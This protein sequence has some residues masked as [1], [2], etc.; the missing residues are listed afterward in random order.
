MMSTTVQKLL[1]LTRLSTDKVEHKFETIDLSEII[2]SARQ[3]TGFIVCEIK[4]TGIGIP[5]GDL[6][7]VFDRF[8]QVDKSRSKE[9]GSSGLG[10]SICHEIVKLHGGAGKLSHPTK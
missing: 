5:E 9:I 8:Y 10:L 4:D 6:S 7:K 2:R 1:A 3:E